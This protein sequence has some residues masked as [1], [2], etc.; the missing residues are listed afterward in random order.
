MTKQE[1]INRTERLLH[2]AKG[3]VQSL[4]NQR[5]IDTN[6]KGQQTAFDTPISQ[7]EVEI[8]QHRQTLK[9]LY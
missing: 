1:Q 8:E 2:A 6:Y 5:W 9:E 4:K 3:K 7:I